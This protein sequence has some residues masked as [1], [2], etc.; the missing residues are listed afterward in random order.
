MG[1]AALAEQTEHKRLPV[2]DCKNG[3]LWCNSFQSKSQVTTCRSWRDTDDVIYHCLSK[4]KLLVA[5]KEVYR[6]IPSG[7]HQN[8]ILSDFEKRMILLS[9]HSKENSL[10]PEPP[11]TQGRPSEEQLQKV[12]TVLANTV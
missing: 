2:T 7:I 10:S 12:Q 4:R 3:V 11:S 8:P 9:E 6:M 5:E 1:A